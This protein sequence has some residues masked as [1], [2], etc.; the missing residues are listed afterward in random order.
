MHQLKGSLDE[1]GS[2]VE[3]CSSR[4]TC[5]SDQRCTWGWPAW[6]VRIDTANP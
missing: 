3:V 4:S 2:S 5:R 1:V 6:K